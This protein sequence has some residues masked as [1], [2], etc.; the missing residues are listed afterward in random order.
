MAQAR[1][2]CSGRRAKTVEP[3]LTGAESGPLP[4]IAALTGMHGR[5]LPVPGH[6]G[7]DPSQ[8]MSNGAGRGAELEEPGWRIRVGRTRRERIRVESR[9]YENSGA[10]ETG[11]RLQRQDP[12]QTGRLRRRTRQCQ[13]VDESVRR[14]RRRRGAAPEGGRQGD[15]GGGG[16]DRCRAGLRDHPHRPRHGRRSRHPGQD[17]SAARA[18]HRRQAPQGRRRQ[19][20]AGPRIILGKQAID[21]DCNQ[22]GQMLA[23]LSGL[24][25]GHLCLEGRDRGG[26]GRRDARGGRRLAD[27]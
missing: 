13:D 15:R 3:G 19:G 7:S 10:R 4:E 5:D 17:R 23:A 21:D 11:G 25:P 14:N 6:S 1:R 20:G 22:T 16:V 2:T 8:P 9:G 24:A 18:A 26:H 12:R 27:A